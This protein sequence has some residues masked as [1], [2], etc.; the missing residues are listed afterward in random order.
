MSEE[1]IDD[2]MKEQGDDASLRVVTHS[3]ARHKTAL[4]FPPLLAAQVVE[5]VSHAEL[6]KYVAPE[7]LPPHLGG[8]NTVPVG[9]SGAWQGQWA[10]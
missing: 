4:C 8:T 5:C 1:L 10:G 7:V 9:E 2:N 6:H 3:E